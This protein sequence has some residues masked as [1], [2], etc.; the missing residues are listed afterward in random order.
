MMFLTS[1]I[2]LETS[3]MEAP[4]LS[5]PV[6]SGHQYEILKTIAYYYIQF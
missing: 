3:D 5:W 4:F 1:D 2:V 6:L